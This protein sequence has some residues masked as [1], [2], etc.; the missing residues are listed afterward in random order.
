MLFPE[1]KIPFI[2]LTK[3]TYGPS[4]NKIKQ[5]SSIILCGTNIPLQALL[6]WFSLITYLYKN[7]PGT[8]FHIV[9]PFRDTAIKK[10]DWWPFM[11]LGYGPLL[12]ELSGFQESDVGVIHSLEWVS[13]VSCNLA[14][15]GTPPS[16]THTP[17]LHPNFP[18]MGKKFL[19]EDT[20]SLSRGM[21]QLLVGIPSAA[22][23][24]QFVLLYYAAAAWP[25]SPDESLFK[26]G[27][28][29]WL[30]QLLG[31]RSPCFQVLLWLNKMF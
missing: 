3:F 10:F 14:D 21:L 18:W 5:S 29:V 22:E 25:L 11:A 19:E 7:S 6:W 27:S 30:F 13:L 26:N 28:S 17:N 31:T 4:K 9:L 1:R 24:C 23:P 12:C 16:H 15:F 8:H 20:V 2:R